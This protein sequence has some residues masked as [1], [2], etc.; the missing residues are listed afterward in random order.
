MPFLPNDYD[1]NHTF[2]N[3]NQP[4]RFIR[5]QTAYDTTSLKL[6]TD[7][8]KRKLNPEQLAIYNS[9]TSY[10]P[11]N[12]I[13]NTNLYFVDGP[14]RT[15]RTLLYNAILANIRSKGK[16]A[17]AVASSGI[18]ACLLD[19]GQTAHSVFRIPLKIFDDSV[20]KI[21]TNSDLAVSFDNI[22]KNLI[23]FGNKLIF[24]W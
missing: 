17:I 1:P 5:T 16:I 12:T 8:C 10:T 4:N 13:R 3:V 20:C 23:P 19:G 7:A 11:D 9:L 24:S 14:G 15:A 21:N 18:A 22:E 6:F 2:L